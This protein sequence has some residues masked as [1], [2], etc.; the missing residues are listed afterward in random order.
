MSQLFAFS[1]ARPTEPVEAAEPRYS[2]DTQQL[3]WTGDGESTMGYT[4]CTA[5]R[6]SGY[7]PCSLHYVGSYIQCYGTRCSTSG[8]TGCYACDYA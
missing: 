2:A 4:H 6:Y 7:N 1:V 3:V 5:G 8:Y